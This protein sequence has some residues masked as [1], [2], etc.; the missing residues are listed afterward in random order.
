MATFTIN[1]STLLKWAG[2][3]ATLVMALAAMVELRQGCAPSP[4]PPKTVSTRTAAVK[5]RPD[6][7]LIHDTVT[8]IRWRISAPANYYPQIA[9]D[10]SLLTQ[11]S[12][13]I[14]Q[15]DT[16]MQA[17][18]Q[19]RLRGLLPDSSYSCLD[20]AIWTGDTAATGPDTMSIC[21]DKRSDL[22]RVDIQPAIRRYN[23]E[24]YY[25]ARDS[26][27]NI[28]DSTTI[29]RTQKDPITLFGHI[30]QYLGVAFAGYILGK[31]F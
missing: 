30:L 22:F 13:S 4:I 28:F 25:T 14:P 26:V 2:G 31:F 24:A 11:K 6:S 5:L 18:M 29:T 15:S 8:L 20:T 19:N 27:I 7:V 21:F 1:Q 10:T 12:D 17:L 9:H 16:A 23:H 3:I